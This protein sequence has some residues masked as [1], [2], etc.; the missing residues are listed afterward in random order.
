MLK[1][2]SRA[3]RV[4]PGSTGL[5]LWGDNKTG[6]GRS[7]ESPRLGRITNIIDFHFTSSSNLGHGNHSVSRE[8]ALNP[9]H[10]CPWVPHLDFSEPQF[11][12]LK[13]MVMPQRMWCRLDGCKQRAGL[14]S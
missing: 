12:R 13:L 2:L 4:Q 3:L 10:L 6:E 14:W 5:G 9:P 11:P 1:G 8:L 7:Q